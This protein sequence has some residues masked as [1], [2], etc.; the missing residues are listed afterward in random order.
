[1]ANPAKEITGRVDAM[2]VEGLE[3][4]DDIAP[5]ITYQNHGLKRTRRT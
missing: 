5:H 4:G 1:M 2:D 3:L